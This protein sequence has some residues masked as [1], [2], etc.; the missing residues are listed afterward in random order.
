MSQRLL[1][2]LLRGS[3]SSSSSSIATTSSSASSHVARSATRCT[4]HTS[5]I[6][7]QNEGHPAAVAATAPQVGSTD[8][9]I[10]LDPF[11]QQQVFA[12]SLALQNKTNALGP[13]EE[14]RHVH[15]I[16]SALH[17][18][19]KPS[20]QTLV[21]LSTHVFG[22]T[23]RRDLL[24]SAVVWY[25][26]G[27]RRGGGS[28]KTRAE[29]SGSGRKLRP[30]KGTGRARLGDR[31]SPVL[32]GGGVAHGP[33][34]RDFSSKLNRKVRE[35][36]LRSALSLRWRAGDLFVVPNLAWDAPPRI[37]G[38]LRRLLGSKQWSDALF[39]TAPRE[40]L[41]LGLARAPNQKPSAV[42]PQYDVAKIEAHREI[43]RHFQLASCNIPKVS[44]IRLHELGEKKRAGAKK[45]TREAKEPGELHAY[46][47]LKRKR[48][49]LDLGALEWIEEYLGGS[50]FHA[51]DLEETQLMLREEEEEDVRAAAMG[52]AATEELLLHSESDVVEEG[53]QEQKEE[54]EEEAE[55]FLN[56]AGVDSLG[57][58]ANAELDKKETK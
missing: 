55:R 33:K 32:R 4:I 47:I 3:S 34:P 7:R 58:D 27:L 37:T 11:V 57:H 24:H 29:V 30:Q 49:I 36:A 56:E 48:L 23:P 44:L 28:T 43:T 41:S 22:S 1:R 15:V 46:E 53:E 10:D 38:E 19:T 51:N 52:A 31:G 26:D 13:L 9:A 39:L 18:S 6:R 21:P 5:A 42:E 50:I 16:M 54:L 17:P 45:G 25:L 20:S 14:S 8:L 2:P 12:D 40:P 35:M